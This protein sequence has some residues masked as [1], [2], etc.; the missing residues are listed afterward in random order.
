MTK[1]LLDL[2]EELLQT[3]LDPLLTGHERQPA[4]PQV[5]VRVLYTDG[6]QVSNTNISK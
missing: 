2:V 3:E 5:R 1:Y 6:R 4:L